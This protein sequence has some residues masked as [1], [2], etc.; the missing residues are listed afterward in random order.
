MSR[1][2]FA[3]LLSELATVRV[4]CKNPTCGG[5]VELPVSRLSAQHGNTICHI[6]GANFQ[7]HLS[8]E[9]NPF[10][11]LAVAFQ[12]IKQHADKMDVEFVVPEPPS[13]N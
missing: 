8:N 10:T 1:R 7:T 13:A 2:L 12:Q 3:F 4:I 6:C 5:V 11:A 9:P